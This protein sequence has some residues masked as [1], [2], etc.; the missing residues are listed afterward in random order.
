MS[1][2]V[3]DI[4]TKFELCTLIKSKVIYNMGFYQIAYY[5]V[6][7]IPQAKSV[8]SM[9]FTHSYISLKHQINLSEDKAKNSKWTQLEY[10]HL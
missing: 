4:C 9:A 8:L 2:G 10:L 5:M 3:P 1:P 6:Q 7:K